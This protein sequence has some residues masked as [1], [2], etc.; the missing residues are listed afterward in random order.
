M[1]AAV[2]TLLC[3]TKEDE[4]TQ[5]MDRDWNGSEGEKRKSGHVPLQQSDDRQVKSDFQWKS[6]ENTTYYTALQDHKKPN[7]GSQV[8]VGSSHFVTLNLWCPAFQM[9]Q[10]ALRTCSG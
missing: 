7:W 4:Y 8:V 10:Y 2:S 3:M 6:A 1:P 9:A 5:R